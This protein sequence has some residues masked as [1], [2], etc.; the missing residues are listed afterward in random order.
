MNNEINILSTVFDKTCHGWGC[1]ISFKFLTNP[2]KNGRNP[3]WVRCS[4]RK[5][6]KDAYSSALMQIENK[7]LDEKSEAE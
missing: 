3:K 1:T 4:K 2:P 7:L 5:T 6:K